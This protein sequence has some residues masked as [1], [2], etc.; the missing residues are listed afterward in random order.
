MLMQVQHTHETQ[1]FAG[2]EKNRKEH[3]KKNNAQNMT[4]PFDGASKSQIPFTLKFREVRHT[5]QEHTGI[6][7]LQEDVTIEIIRPFGKT[8]GEPRCNE[9]K[10]TQYEKIGFHVQEGEPLF[11]LGSAQMTHSRAQQEKSPAVP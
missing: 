7:F 10:S 8:S 4:Y 11:P 6:H 2:I 9:R 1:S 5:H 3:K